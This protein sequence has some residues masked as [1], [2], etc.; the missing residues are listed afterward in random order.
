MIHCKHGEVRIDGTALELSADVTIIIHSFLKALNDEDSLVKDMNNHIV[1]SVM[2]AF[3]R[4]AN[5]MGFDINFSQE[6]IDKFENIYNEV[7][8]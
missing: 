2:Y 7:F 6:E 4:D 8:T 3:S 1:K 5:K